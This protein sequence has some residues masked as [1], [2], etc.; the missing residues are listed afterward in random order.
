MENLIIKE[1]K[2]TPL[3]MFDSEKHT[4]EIN[5]GSYPEN[6]SDFY[7]PVFEWLEKYLSQL[8]DNQ[9]FTFN[10]RI[11]YFNSSSLKAL[12]NIFNMLEKSAENRTNVIINWYYDKDN[13]IVF[14][15]GEEFME[16]SELIT[17]NLV[18]SED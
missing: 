8:P 15:H 7:N 13:D 4:L 17:F 2:Y 5:G 6:T 1:T 10:I 9:T 14:E 12:M 16:D 3:I 11:I 18:V